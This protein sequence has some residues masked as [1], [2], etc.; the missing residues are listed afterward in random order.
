MTPLFA[1]WGL[2]LALWGIFLVL[3]A[4]LAVVSQNISLIRTFAGPLE[5]SCDAATGTVMGAGGATGFF[6]GEGAGLA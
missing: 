4:Q 1:Q 6:A 2:R 5:P 3:A